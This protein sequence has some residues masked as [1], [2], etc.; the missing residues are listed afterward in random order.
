MARVKDR[1][2]TEFRLGERD[3]RAP[4]QPGPV[5]KHSLQQF[6]VVG[7]GVPD[8]HLSHGRTGTR[9]LGG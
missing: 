5:G 6:A 7:G 4:Q 2:A 9:S 3:Q 8:P 1:V